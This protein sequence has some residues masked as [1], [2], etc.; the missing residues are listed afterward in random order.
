MN[1]NDKNLS[2]R[3]EPSRVGDHAGRNDTVSATKRL[4]T[5]GATLAITSTGTLLV[6]SAM[7]V[8]AAAGLLSSGAAGDNLGRRWMFLAGMI[9]LAA[10]SVLGALAPTTLVL[11]ISRILQGIGGAAIMACS[12]GLIGHEYPSGDGRKR[13]TAVW[14]AALG[15]GVAIG[16]ILSA[17]LADLGG[18]RLPYVFTALAATP[19]AIAGRTLPES[20]AA[21]PRRIDVAGTLLLGLGLAAVLAGLTESRTGWSRPSVGLLLVSGLVLVIGFL[22]VEHRI[23]EP[24]LDLALFRR[25]EFVAATIAALAAGI[26]VLSLLSLVPTLLERALGINALIAAIVLLGWSGTTVPTAYAVRWLPAWVTPHALLIGGLVGCAAGQLALFGLAPSS[27][28]LRVLPGLLVAG[29]ANGVLNAA[30]GHEA[31]ASVPADRAAMGS[32]ANNTARYLGSATGL[33]VVTVLMT[34]GEAT[35]GVTGLISGWNIAVLV[36][37]GLSLLG[38]GVVFYAQKGKKRS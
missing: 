7:S 24:M 11:V 10:S 31:V 32:G 38:A 30:L 5:E 29:V 19:L 20:R 13:A 33:T 15:A 27:S 3:A 12:L 35:S 21:Q 16:P 34:H 26:G 37:T 28:V 14:G 36:T 23:K 17:W 2:L 22:A 9:F 1:K 8:G 4:P 18:W 25:P 6:L